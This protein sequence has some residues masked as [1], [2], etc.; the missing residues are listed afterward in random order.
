MYKISLTAIVITTILFSCSKNSAGFRLSNFETPII[1]GYEERDSNGSLIWQW[2]IPNIKT[3]ISLSP[4]EKQYI[5]A[6]FPNPCKNT[7][8]IYVKSL[9]LNSIK[10]LWIVKAI[11][12]SESF[13]SPIALG[14]NNFEIGG[15]PVFQLEF[16]Q[17]HLS[18]DINNLDEGFYRIYVKVD[19]HI[20]YDNIVILN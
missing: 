16:T 12:D 18:V 3:S 17:E 6:I 13:T 9:S 20:L 10:K 8:Q 5:F 14:M 19:N 1:T 15:S 2:G 7:C 11:A 4:E